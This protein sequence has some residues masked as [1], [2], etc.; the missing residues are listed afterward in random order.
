MNKVIVIGT[1]HTEVGLCTSDE[2]TKIIEDISPSII[3]CEAAHE[4][5]DEMLKANDDFNTPEIKVLREII[6]KGIIEV[7]PIDVNENPFDRRLEAMFELFEKHIKEYSY[8]SEIQFNEAFRLGFSYLNSEDS[9]QIHRDKSAMEKNFVERAKNGQLSKMHID[10]L[11]WNDKRE[12]HWI[13]E[14]HDYLKKYKTSN[15]LLLV[16]SAHRIGLMEKIKKLLNSNEFIPNW[17]FTILGD[18][19]AR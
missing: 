3:F 16:G 18:L 2:L 9:D 7:I 6:H 11:E 13:D 14:I 5:F 10:W 19:Y 12:K 15:A 4:V 17:D 1:T 8:A